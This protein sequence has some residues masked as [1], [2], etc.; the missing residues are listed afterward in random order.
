MPDK[1]SIKNWRQI[2]GLT[3]VQMAKKMGMSF[4]KYNAIESV[5]GKLLAQIADV[6]HINVND[7][8]I[9]SDLHG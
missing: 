5:N 8:D 4:A 9:G 3:Q 6:L 1:L 2:R 7:I